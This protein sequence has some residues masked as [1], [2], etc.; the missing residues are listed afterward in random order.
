MRAATLLVNLSLA[1]VIFLASPQLLGAKKKSPACSTLSNEEWRAR[2]MAE[3]TNIDTS[4]VHPVI[5]P[6]IQIAFNEGPGSFVGFDKPN[7]PGVYFARGMSGGMNRESIINSETWKLEL[8]RGETDEL[9]MG[10]P[11]KYSRFAYLLKSTKMNE[12]VADGIATHSFPLSI[13]GKSSSIESQYNEENPTVV[14]GPGFTPRGLIKLAIL[15]RTTSGPRAEYYWFQE[16]LRLKRRLVAA[17]L[18]IVP[19][20]PASRLYRDLEIIFENFRY[21]P[22]ESRIAPDRD[23]L[24]EDVSEPQQLVGQMSSLLNQFKI[25]RKRK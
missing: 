23:V 18:V 20:T 17:G 6:Y 3:S 1:F 24:Y 16:L 9:L 13:I 2:I 21:T 10:T 8:A 11:S 19:N 22:Y 12:E 14:L 7:E 15:K 25:A 4:V 5:A